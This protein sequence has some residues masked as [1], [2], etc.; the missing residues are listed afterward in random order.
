MAVAV[1][2]VF[3]KGS[4]GKT[5]Y[6][7]SQIAAWTAQGGRAL[8]IVPDQASYNAERQLAASMPGRGFRGVQ[9]VGF[10]RLAYRVFQERGKEHASLSELSRR[11]MV[12][13]ILRRHQDE[14]SVLQTAA[15]QDTFAASASRFI[16]ECRSFCIGP[17]A[18]RQAAQSL[19]EQTLARKLQDMAVL[20]DAYEQFLQDH[21]GSAD[22]VMTLLARE[23][24]SYTFLQGARIWVD[25]FQWF[26]PQ[27]LE[28]LR[29]A[30]KGARSMTITLTMDSEHLSDQA[31]ETALFHRPYE[32]YRDLQHLFPQLE[33]VTVSPQPAKGIAQFAADFFHAVPKK[34]TVPVEGLSLLECSTRE[35]E[36]DAV[37]RQILALCRQGYRYRDMLILVRSGDVYHHAAERVFSRYGIPFFSDYRRPMLSHPVA[38]AATALL[39]V[40]RSRWSYD[41]MFRLLKSDLFPIS[42]ADADEL[43]NYCLAYG[44]QGYHWLSGQDWH[45][46]RNPYLEASHSVDAGEEEKLRRINAIRQDVCRRLLPFWED[47]Q[48]DHALTEWCS[49]LYH[50]LAALETPQTLRR[51]KEDDE[52][53]G[54]SEGAKEHEQ[55]WKGLLSFLDEI[56]HLCGDDVVTLEEFY[57]MLT[58]GLKDLTFSLIPPTLDHVT[59]TAVDRGY[60]M[61]ARAVF[62]CG[63]NDGVFPQRCSEEGILS[64]TER[65]RLTALGVKLGPGGRFRSFQEKFLFYLAVTRTTERLCISYVMA[66]EDGDALE[67]SAWVRQLEDNGYVAAVTRVSGSPEAGQERDYLMAMPA[68]L[69]WLPEKLRPAA[70]GEKTD[71]IW[72]SLYDWACSH[73][74]HDRARRAV[75]G[76]FYS[77][78]PAPLPPSLVRRL[79]APDGTLRGSVTKFEQYRSCPF[80]YFSRYGLNLEERPM[81]RFAAPDLGMLVH[82]ALR[83][84]GDDLLAQKKQW[85]D[86]APEAI[87]ALCRDATEKLAPYVQHDILMTNAY[88]AH[89]KERLIQTLTRTVRRLCQFS[90][91]S[92][93][94]MEG[95]EKSFGR[96]GSTWEALRFTLPDGL[97]VI[98][99]GQIDRID[100]MRSGHTK[101]VVVI[102]YKSGRKKLALDQVYAGLELQLLTYMYVALLNIGGDAMPAA[103]L[104]CYVRNDKTTLDHAVTD[105]EKQQLYDKSSRLSGFYLN[106]GTVM[107]ALDTSMQD[108]SAFLTMRLKKDGTMSNSGNTM[109]D[110]L[111]WQHLLDLAKRRI[112]E[113]AESISEGDIAV[114]PLLLGSLSPCR[115]CPYHGVCRFDVQL[116]DNTY[117]TTANLSKEE[118]L[119][120]MDEEGGDTHGLDTGSAGSH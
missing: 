84:L 66:G 93:F 108:Y 76:L 107:Q 46:G 49:L 109:Y 89:I 65:R 104:Y 60:T 23:I 42:R 81:Y 40:F 87:P 51:W 68:A 85:H 43:E 64:D 57:T 72:W 33:T 7:C 101:Y 38:E 53:A 50:W 74:W 21:F 56:V 110:E 95:L 78:Q 114:R 61:R 52:E 67:P 63:V 6:C 113:I 11:I 44:I 30:E 112:V 62:L 59:L 75:Q 106:D 3:G 9:V 58:D 92:D 54:D 73:G 69:A 55:V 119:K 80:A 5:Q 27:Q 117:D 116:G 99:S 34:R 4:G 70:E 16:L 118:L 28:V 10:S 18:L 111:G 86:L 83:I 45:Y 103:I 77:N 29:L 32:V 35:A 2:V 100:T 20:Y 79:Y 31:R 115:Y 102:D 41:A 12:R 19:G 13:R 91:V 17:E 26:T 48:H 47:V 88:F 39:D 14:L 97:E 24:G 1:T 36:L 98:V 71:N 120:R 15:G 82:G 25:G 37:A 8:L 105:E 22:D 94:H 96:R 90:A